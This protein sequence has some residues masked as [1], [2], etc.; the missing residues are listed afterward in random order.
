MDGSTATFI[1]N[2]V[3][4]QLCDSFFGWKGL[5]WQH[6]VHHCAG[7]LAWGLP[8]LARSNRTIVAL[9]Y[10][11]AELPNPFWSTRFLLRHWGVR[12]AFSRLNEYCF[13][14]VWIAGRNIPELWASYHHAWFDADGFPLA[15][16]ATVAVGNL[17]T[18]TWSLQILRMI[19]RKLLPLGGAAEAKLQGKG[20]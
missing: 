6:K 12:N 14:V 5:S 2:F 18:V 10:L 7:I 13:A 3:G 15:W 11:L 19:R 9:A 20:A 17:L 8:L 4:Y 16:R 1:A